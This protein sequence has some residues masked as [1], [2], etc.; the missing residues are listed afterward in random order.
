MQ[1]GEM[2]SILQRLEDQAGRVFT[3]AEAASEALF[4]HGGGFG[5]SWVLKQGVLNKLHTQ[6]GKGVGDRVYSHVWSAIGAA[7]FFK[8]GIER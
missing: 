5:I 1:W 6:L 8:D 3:T 4:D 7:E 2:R